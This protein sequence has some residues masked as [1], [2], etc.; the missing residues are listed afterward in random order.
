MDYKRIEFL[1]DK[2]WQC[3]TTLEEE[4]ELRHCFTCGEE[5]PE[6]LQQFRELFVLQF[7]ERQVCLTEDFNRKILS[8]I[9][10]RKVRRP[11]RKQII[12]RVAGVVILLMMAGSVFLWQQKK[13]LPSEPQTPEQALAEVQRA[14][15]FVSL[16]LNRGQQIVEQNM[17]ELEV[18][19][20]FIK[21]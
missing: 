18:V 16:K 6:Y 3:E 17:E 8:E 5:L 20:Q 19:T 11:V 12:F 13:Y 7:R 2:F 4:E 10:K 14:L 9:R 21:E 1:L 15:S